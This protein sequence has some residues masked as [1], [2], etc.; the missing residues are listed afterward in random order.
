M[1]RLGSEATNIRLHAFLFRT[2]PWVK[3]PRNSI[4]FNFESMLYCYEIKA[5][6][7]KNLFSSYFIIYKCKE[8]PISL[9]SYQMFR[10]PY[11]FIIIYKRKEVPLSLF[12]YQMLA[13]TFDSDERS[14]YYKVYGGR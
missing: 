10:E 3:Y 11:Y 8:V 9:F 2:N 4:F 13:S 5:Y 1:T 6:F 14:S 7:L 12:S